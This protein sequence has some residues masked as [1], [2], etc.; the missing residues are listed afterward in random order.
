LAVLRQGRA[1][2]A[3]GEGLEGAEAVDKFGG[4]IRSYS[5]QIGLD[6]TCWASIIVVR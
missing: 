4:S 2:L 5:S 1:E 6:Q 3:G